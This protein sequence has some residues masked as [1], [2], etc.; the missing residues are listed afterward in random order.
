MLR[1][2]QRQPDRN[3]LV[4]VHGQV[5]MTSILSGVIAEGP[6]PIGVLMLLCAPP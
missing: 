2:A 6:S 3:A 5:L 4:P 1:P